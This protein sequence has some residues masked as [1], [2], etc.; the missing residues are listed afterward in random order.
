MKDLA[1]FIF[2]A[3]GNKVLKDLTVK[4][5]GPDELFVQVPEKMGES[6]I[7]IYLD[8][9]LLP[10]LPA[11]AKQKDFGKNTKQIT[12][13][14]FEYEKMEA[15]NGTSQK[16]DIEWDDHYDQSMNGVNMQVMKISGLKYVIV[17]DKF[18]LEDIEDDEVKD[19][20]YN[21]FNGLIEDKDDIPFD[22]V[23]NADN[24]TWK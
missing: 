18:E 19:T 3:M 10:K 2:E 9:T 12:D 16:A 7:Q 1:D 15:A 8:D 24:I 5:D 14:Y 23:L 4:Y 11:E 6:D 13:T 21:L 20:V 17:F 22:L